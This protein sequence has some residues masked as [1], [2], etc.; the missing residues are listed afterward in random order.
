MVD[1]IE[2]RFAEYSKNGQRTLGLACKKLAAPSAIGK[3][4]ET[5]MCF[6][7]FVLFTDPPKPGIAATIQRLRELGVSLKIITGDNA[8][9]AESVA[10]QI[11]FENALVL[12]GGELRDMSDGALLNRVN[13]VNVFAEVEPNQKERLIQAL[14]KAGNVVGYMGDGINDASAE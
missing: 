4:D 1:Q 3:G 13:K 11:G 14:R 6:I 7:G 2:T 10:H 9:V 5:G 8:L 12:S